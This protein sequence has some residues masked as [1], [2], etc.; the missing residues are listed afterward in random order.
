MRE[1][2]GENYSEIVQVDKNPIASASIAQ[3]HRGRLSTGEDVAVKVQHYYMKNQIVADLLMYR[4][5]SRIY[6]Y[7]FE[8]PMTMFTRYVLDQ[9]HHE[10]SFIQERKNGDK[11]A[12]MI[13][14]DKSAKELNVH[15][16]RTYPD[17]LTDRVLIT[18]WIDGVSM[19]SRKRMEAAGY[20]V[21]TAMTQYLSLFGRQFFKY[22][23]VHSDPH[24][25]NLMVR[26]D[27]NKKQQLVIL[28]HGL[29]ITLPDKFRCQFRD[30]WQYI[31]SLNTKG[32]Q[33][34]SEDWGIGSSGTHTSTHV[35]YQRYE[36]FIQRLFERRETVSDGIALLDANAA[37]DS[38]PKSPDG[39]SREPDQP[40]HEG[41]GGR[42]V[43]G[44]PAMD[45]MV[46]LVES[47][48]GTFVERCG[49]LD[50]P[51][52]TVD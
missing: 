43:V 42:C 52:Q 22:G 16:P 26:F 9:M 33:Q 15:V 24:P 38:E 36:E 20:N 6:E 27:S 29:Y 1:E 5:I 4:L 39:K 25:G 11:L 34:I 21:A 45:N 14:Q 41:A 8:L 28:D 30:L 19:V 49:V 44:A 18:E 3:V 51:H 32:I 35:E 23:F 10:T 47:K 17:V 7:V 13:A 37:H 46:G 48:S 40:F 12:Q 50:L 2:L 31:F